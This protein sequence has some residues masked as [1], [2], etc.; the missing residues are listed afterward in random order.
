MEIRDSLFYFTVRK[1]FLMGLEN[2]PKPSNMDRVTICQECSKRKSYVQKKFMYTL[3]VADAV[4][5]AIQLTFPIPQTS[6][7]LQVRNPES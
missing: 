1:N 6:Y 2:Y 3:S 4:G 5:A 7:G